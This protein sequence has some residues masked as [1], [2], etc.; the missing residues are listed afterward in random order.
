MKANMEI[1][2][3]AQSA[4]VPLYLLAKH[5]GVS[6]ATMV[7]KLRFELSRSEKENLLDA[8]SI[9]ASK[10]EETENAGR[11]IDSHADGSEV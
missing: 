9:L 5:I 7:R 10:K 4:K 1:R 11:S 3:A 6:E 2:K 8:I